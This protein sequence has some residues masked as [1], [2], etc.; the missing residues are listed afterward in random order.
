MID[1]SA[2]AAIS[3]F[4]DFLFSHSRVR[5]PRSLSVV[6]SVLALTPAYGLTV[7]CHSLAGEGVI[8]VN[9]KQKNQTAVSCSFALL[10]CCCACVIVV[11]S[12]I[13]G[14]DPQGLVTF[15]V[16]TSVAGPVL[17]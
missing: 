15:F 6:S 2:R 3:P 14:S 10:T 4:R 9:S 1:P 7:L 17:G 12:S 13:P 8:Q 16:S 5:F 11:V